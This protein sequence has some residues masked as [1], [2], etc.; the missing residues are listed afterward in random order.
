[1]RIAARNLER[2]CATTNIIVARSQK[3]KTGKHVWGLQFWRFQTRR[4]MVPLETVSVFRNCIAHGETHCNGSCL[5]YF[6]PTVV[7]G[8]M[9]LLPKSL[10]YVV[11]NK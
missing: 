3:R 2:F 4:L 11:N 7:R 6:C 8:R 10:M 9:P 1:M 5:C